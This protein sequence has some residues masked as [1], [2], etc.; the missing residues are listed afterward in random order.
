M[1]TYIY[2]GKRENN[3]WEQFE[4]DKLILTSAQVDETGY[5]EV[6]LVDTKHD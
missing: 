5:T 6:R 2:E 3:V 1:R 4:A